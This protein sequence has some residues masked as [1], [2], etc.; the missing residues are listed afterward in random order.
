MV[1]NMSRNRSGNINRWFLHLETWGLGRHLWVS[2]AWGWIL[3]V[4]PAAG[5]HEAYQRNGFYCFSTPASSSGLLKRYQR[6]ALARGHPRVD[7]DPEK[8]CHPF[9][10]HTCHVSSIGVEW[11]VLRSLLWSV[12]SIQISQMVSGVETVE[13][14]HTA[15]DHCRSLGVEV[16]SWQAE[17]TAHF[18]WASPV[19][20]V[21]WFWK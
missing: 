2:S 3:R 8:N 13:Q 5:W 14:V 11:Y 1:D 19:K 20:S 21:S 9:V 17:S 16:E 4:L 18:Q 10:T 7:T 6:A 15:H 12:D